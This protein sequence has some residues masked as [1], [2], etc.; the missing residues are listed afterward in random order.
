MDSIAFVIRAQ[1][2]AENLRQHHRELEKK[3]RFPEQRYV[4]GLSSHVFCTQAHLLDPPWSSML[5][6]LNLMIWR[7]AT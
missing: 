5:R 3:L 2:S 4:S 6:T 7:H 1:W